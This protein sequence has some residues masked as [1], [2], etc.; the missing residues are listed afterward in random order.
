MKEPKEPSKTFY[1]SKRQA[2]IAMR[3]LLKRDGEFNIP[4]TIS[5]LSLETGLGKKC[6]Q[7]I[8]NNL[9]ETGELTIKGNQALI[10]QQTGDTEQINENLHSAQIQNSGGS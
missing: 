10:T 5:F 7:G 2:A 3:R 8:L 6:I 9:L 4:R 1:E